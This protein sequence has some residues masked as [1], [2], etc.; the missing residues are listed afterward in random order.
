MKNNLKILYLFL[1]TLSNIYGQEGIIEIEEVSVEEEPGTNPIP[2]AVVEDAPRFIG[3]DGSSNSEIKR[4]TSDSIHKFVKDHL[5]DLEKTLGEE[6]KKR[7]Y[8]QFIITKEGKIKDVKTRGPSPELEKEAK[9][10]L[11]LLPNMIP[12]KQRGKAVEVSYSIPI[13]FS[14]N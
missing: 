4:C 3:C 6:G 7:V 1:I 14:E 9:R 11:E 5:I 8:G 2:F 10:I 12:G 13:T